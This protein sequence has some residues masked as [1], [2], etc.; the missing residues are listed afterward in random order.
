MAR[1]REMSTINVPEAEL[2]DFLGSFTSEVPKFPDYA[3]ALREQHI[4]PT[5]YFSL[6]VE[7]R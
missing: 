5:V 2:R 6:N 4:F 3:K 7:A 1:R